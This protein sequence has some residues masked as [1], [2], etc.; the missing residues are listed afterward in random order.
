[1]K[2]V[3]TL[4]TGS[5][6]ATLAV[7]V[8][9][10]RVSDGAID[11]RETSS[12]LVPLIDEVLLKAGLELADLDAIVALAG[13]GSFTGLR[14]GLATV[15]GL[16]RATGIR[17]GTLPTHLVLAAGAR[18]D[19]PP[20]LAAVDA[21]RDEWSV[22]V[23]QPGRPPRP[24]ADRRLLSTQELL[25]APATLVGFDIPEHDDPAVSPAVTALRGDLIEIVDWGVEALTR[26]IYARP[27]ATT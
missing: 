20:I 22:Q 27:P 3:L 25:L 2:N 12:Q 14:I 7:G 26:P 23:F 18:G 17:A 16:H 9:G 21:L 8:D 10:R 11:Q 5:P 15:L 24:A 1:M 4:D 6:I 19:N 13:P